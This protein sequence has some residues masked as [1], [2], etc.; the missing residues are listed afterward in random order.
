MFEN[1]SY[2]GAI[3]NIQ[4]AKVDIVFVGF[5]IKDY[6]ADD[7]EFS[8]PVYQDQLCIMTRKAGKVPSAL[9]PL[10]IFERK[11]WASILVTYITISIFWCI[12]RLLNMKYC[13]S[14][15]LN[16][17]SY[18]TRAS[19]A[20]IMLQMF[21][22]TSVLIFNSPFRRFPKVQSERILIASICLFS[23][24][25]IAAY[26]SSLATAYTRPTY[27]KN[28]ET[29]EELDKSGMTIVSK[30]KGFLDD[31]FPPNASPLTD[32]L[33]KKVVWNET[34]LLVLRLQQFREAGFTRKS[35]FDITYKSKNFHLI[36]E[37]PRK[38]RLA[39]AVPKGFALLE[40]LNVNLLRLVAGGVVNKL[41]D[42]VKTKAHLSY[43]VQNRDI[44]SPTLKV[45]S[46][47]DLQ[48]GFYVLAVGSAAA[49]FL[50]IVEVLVKSCRSRKKCN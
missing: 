22:D 35:L 37:C 31:A 8:A 32:R 41:I 33:L 21:L 10:L 29:L 48:L 6:S 28:I 26:Q 12:L 24:I 11:L 25:V 7:I 3:G 23:L 42:D 43:Y 30:Y 19:K 50:L 39:Y 1:G 16:M 4:K 5:F 46:L 2:N 36:P 47:S 13:S 38:Y 49:S 20:T 18:L 17:P 34:V 14:S 40:M 45:F 9:L 44:F 15:A 27:Y